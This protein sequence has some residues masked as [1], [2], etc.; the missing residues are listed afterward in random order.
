[1]D[2][3]MRVAMSVLVTIC[4]CAAQNAPA[5]PAQTSSAEH[6]PILA[7][8]SDLP[9]I[10]GNAVKGSVV[11]TNGTDDAFDQTVVVEA[12]NGIGKAFTL[13]YQ[14]FTLGAHS[15]SKV[16]EF[17]TTLPP[18][19]Y[20]VHA[21]AVAEVPSRGAIY[22]QHLLAPARFVISTL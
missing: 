7:E 18:G 9:K 2:M 11:V 14:H 17:T 6:P 20:Q 16:I 22:R 5:N 8:W 15:Q 21:D 13:G 3:F 1:M 12:V 19:S 4:V 10:S